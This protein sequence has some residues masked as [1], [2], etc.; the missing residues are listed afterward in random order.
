MGS[1]RRR[2]QHFAGCGI[3]LSFDL[4]DETDGYIGYSDANIE[5][6]V[7]GRRMDTG[8]GLKGRGKGSIK[9]GKVRI[10]P[11]GPV[12]IWNREDQKNEA[13]GSIEMIATK[14]LTG[15]SVLIAC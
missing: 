15:E 3:E 8:P 2:I 5:L 10:F 13:P 11:L 4:G 7:D 14:T 6:V 9:V 12:C 1:L